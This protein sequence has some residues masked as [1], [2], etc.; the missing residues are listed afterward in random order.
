[1]F[2]ICQCSSS[3][4]VPQKPVFLIYQCSS[5]VRAPHPPKFHTIYR[6]I[7]SLFSYPYSSVPFYYSSISDVLL[8]PY[9]FFF[10]FV[11]SVQFFFIS[12]LLFVSVPFFLCTILSVL[13]S[14]CTPFCKCPFFG[15]SFI[16]VCAPFYQCSFLSVLLFI[17]FPFSMFSFFSVP[18]ALCTC[19]VFISHFALFSAFLSLSPRHSL[20]SPF[21]A[22]VPVYSSCVFYLLLFLYICTYSPM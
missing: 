5:F 11:L 9:R 10:F 7:C 15:A 6:I 17:S 3:A 22:C 4:N 1:V 19:S 21:L 8:A 20:L 18:F 14:I 16:S 12:V 2:L 13:P